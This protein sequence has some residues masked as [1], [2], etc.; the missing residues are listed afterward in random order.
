MQ[1]D[2][3]TE[4]NQPQASGAGRMQRQASGAPPLL[5]AGTVLVIGLLL[6]YALSRQAES[7]FTSETQARFEA[8]SS[9]AL[10]GVQRRIDEFQAVLLGMQG[11]FIASEHIDRREFQRYEQNLRGQL[12]VPGIRALHF[13][14]RVPATDK[15]AFMAAVRNDR[16]LDASGFPDFAIHPETNRAEHFVIEYIEPFAANRRAF[17]LDAG[18]QPVNLESFIAARDTGRIRFTPPFQLIQSSLGERGLVMRAPVYRYG[19][20]LTSIDGRRDA[21]I[22]L[23]GITI[24][25]G[26]IFNDIFVEPFLAGHCVAIHDLDSSAVGPNPAPVLRLLAENCT[27]EQLVTNRGAGL[28]SATIIPAGGRLWQIHVSARQDWLARQQGRQTPTLILAAGIVISLLLAALYLALARSRSSAEQLAAQMTRNLRQ[29]EQRFRTMAEMSTD[30]FWEQD[31]EGRFTSIVGAGSDSGSKMPLPLDRIRGKTRWEMFP[32]ALTPEQWAAHRRQLMAREAYELEY[33]MLDADGEERWLKVWGAPRYDADGM[34]LGYHGTAHDVTV[35]KRAEVEMA[36]KT[37]VLQATLDNMSQGISVV[38]GDLQMIAL[39]RR[40]CEIL[41]FPPEMGHEGATFESF[42]RYNAERGEYG[43]CDVDAKVAEMIERARNAQAHRFKRT[44]PNGRIVEVVGNPL[45]GGGF[46]TTY[47]DITEQE[48]AEQAI[49]VSEARLKRAELASGSGN[50]EFHLDSQVVIASDGAAKLYGIENV[51]FDMAA[52]RSIPLPEYRPMLD[53]A[54][55][56]LVDDD[57]A[58]DVEFRIKTAD[59]GA[60]RDIHSMARYDRE[61]RVVFGVIQDITERK[62]AEA[63]LLRSEERFSKAFHSS[64]LMVSIARASDGRFIDVNRNYERDFGWKRE[65]LIGRTS[66]DVRLWPDEETR[67]PWAATLL[68]DGRV[69]NWETTWRHRN[70]EPRWVSISAETVDMNGEQCILAFVMDITG[71]RQAAEKLQLAASV[72]THAR[73]GIAITDD[74]GVVIEIN[75]TFTDITGYRREEAVGRN[76]RM[77]KSGRHGPEFYA[78]MWHELAAGGQWYGE[79]WNRRSNGEI[80]PEM[81]TISAVRDAG[82]K[83][84]NYVALFT[85]ITAI[86]EHQQQLEHIAHYD[87]L[88]GLPNRVLLADRLQ[89]AMAQSLRRNQS[90]AVVYL[91]LDGFKP[92]NDVH[93]H[94]VGD[95]LLILVSQRMKA[96]LRE[97]DTLGRLGGDEFV[98]VL[99]DLEQAQDCEPVLARLLLAAAA[100]ATIGKLVLRVSASVGVTLYPQDKSDA[101]QLLRHADL[102]M[103]QAKQAGKNRYHLFDLVQDAA[104]RSQRESLE[105]IRHALEQRQFVLHYQPKVN[106]CSGVVIGAEALI[107][108]QH[109]E[110]GLLS[111]A[112]FLPITENDPVSVD[113]GE[114]VI[115]TALAQMSR[116]RAEGL[117]IPVSVNVG[118]RQLQQADFVSRLSALLAAHPDIP[119][120]H[121]ELE[122]LETNALDDVVQVSAIMHACRAIGVRF[123]L[124][125]FGTG[126]SSLTYLKRLPADLL[127]IDQSFVRTMRD[128]PD[129]LAIVEGVIGLAAAFRRQIIAE[130]VETVAHGE[131]LLMLGCELGQGYGIARP[132]PAAELSGWIAAWRPD[133]AWT[134]RS[135]GSVSRDDLAVVFAE[136]EHR[137]WVRTMEM[138]LARERDEPASLDPHECRFGRWLDTGGQARYGNHPGLAPVV[139]MHERVHSLGRE[140]V[141]LFSHGRHAEAQARLEDLHRRRDELIAG[142]RSLISGSE[143]R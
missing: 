83:T 135:G 71:R 3:T 6:S 123:A 51:Q 7:N 139:A 67:R 37:R 110:R 99:V 73:E 38:D 89:L 97:G 52:I 33:P 69:V 103:Y 22:G 62:Q 125:D 15:A 119:P 21:F 81:L 130:G 58:Y 127:K 14:R 59:T 40:F 74:A 55:K 31:S 79:I 34:F 61:N 90:L 47:T 72:F 91:D 143:T 82:G 140:L 138:F 96:V 78:A 70:G 11:L 101:D 94:E 27:G 106:M 54:L 98:A 65:E 2:D 9:L 141:G 50:W 64:P 39:N 17:G 1:P 43:P 56:N 32:Q 85:D 124:D 115:D 114:W 104:V 68:R 28:T 109:P 66:L 87:S 48:L 60:I 12:R 100:P 133:P 102:A 129:D 128:D 36:R 57:R 93:G 88:T 112:T 122:V 24:D 118:A 111:P 46:V 63:T 80:Y 136:V 92:V 30:W 16:S 26:E 18:S 41:D 105:H 76:M 107:R 45:P 86:K 29:S 131:L 19:A 121:L 10:A 108:W 120:G 44:R 42:I 132:M 75:A 20:Q 137:H 142:L 117:D 126:Y 53:T 35:R 77:L 113:I 8:G 49:R 23:V 95:E 4:K 13:T 5:I 25:A 84:Q 134:A 116:W